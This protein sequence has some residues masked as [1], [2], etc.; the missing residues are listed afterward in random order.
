MVHRHRIPPIAQHIK[1]QADMNRL[2]LKTGGELIGKKNIG[3][4]MVN[5]HPASDSFDVS[6]DIAENEKN[7]FNGYHAVRA[8]T[9]TKDFSINHYN[10]NQVSKNYNP[11]LFNNNKIDS[12]FLKQSEIL[13]MKPDGFRRISI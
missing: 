6:L 5:S 11:K 3:L 1:I 8:R 7:N 12:K 4:G 10:H 13:R 9:H 2:N